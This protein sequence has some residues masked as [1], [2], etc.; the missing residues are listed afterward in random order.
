MMHKQ[1]A[2]IAISSIAGMLGSF[3]PWASGLFGD[4]VFPEEVER[5]RRTTFVLFALALLPTLTGDRQLVLSRGRRVSLVVL[6][7]LFALIGLSTIKMASRV[8]HPGI[9]SLLVLAAGVAI[10]ICAFAFKTDR[11]AAV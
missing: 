8:G 9:G 11:K 1:R 5:I 3:L 6:A 10:G 4:A 2:A 7:V